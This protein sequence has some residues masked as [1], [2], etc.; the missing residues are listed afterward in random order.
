VRGARTLVEAFSEVAAR[1]PGNIAV[2][3]PYGELTYRRLDERAD[4][5]AGQLVRLGAG[6]G[7]VVALVAPRGVELIVG[8]LGILKAGAA[9]LPIDPSYPAARV[10]WTI[11]DSGAPLVVA[12]TRT[13]PVIEHVVEHEA[14]ARVVFLDQLSALAPASGATPPPAAPADVAYVIYTSGSTGSPKGVLVEHH[15]LLRLFDGTAELFG[16]DDGDVWSVF[17]SAAFDFSVWEIWGALLHGGRMV[18]VS[19]STAR[20]PAAFHNLLSDQG[21]TVLSQTPSA[22]RR[23]AA[24]DARCQHRLDALR[25]VVLG[26]E[27]LEP[28]LLRSWWERYG[29]ERPSLINM[30]G[31]TEAVIHASYRRMTSDDVALAGPSPIGC[32]LPGITFH[33]LD[34]DGSPVSPGTAGELHVEGQAL[35]R[36]YLGR[37]ELTARRFLPGTNSDGQVRRLR[38][39]DQVVE[40]PAGEYGYLGRLDDQLKI[41]GFRIEPGEIEAFLTGQPEIAQAVVVPHDYGD[42]DVRLIAYVVAKDAS[43]ALAQTLRERAAAQLPPH[44]CP[45]AYVLLDDIPL[46]ASSKADKARLPAPP[47][48]PGARAGDGHSGLP[49][50]GR[51]IEE[52][53]QNMLG[54][55]SVDRDRGF[56]ELGGTSLTVL[57]MLERVNQTFGTDLDVT[58]LIDG[59]T[60]RALAAQVDAVIPSDQAGPG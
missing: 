27:R 49:D 48:A 8:I 52:I 15:S 14:G 19:P 21:V 24:A 4:A 9:Y 37:P 22:F 36:G 57:R 3:A 43:A 60:V 33:V 45:S 44:L 39:G 51:R 58:V 20:S 32:P 56:F 7:C 11:K 5:L 25:L 28:A 6:P 55:P 23:L 30:Y 50:T 59:A 38:T 29:D 41:R 54:L 53:W 2:T 1:F 35:A 17:H 46:T 42:D 12:T 40:L 10:T 31:I 16:F 18:L 13:A 26:G 34:E 47:G